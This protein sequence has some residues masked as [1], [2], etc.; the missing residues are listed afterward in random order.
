MPYTP[1][2]NLSVNIVLTNDLSGTIDNPYVVSVD[3]ITKGILHVEHGG[4]GLSDIPYGSIVIGDSENSVTTLTG[5][6]NDLL[7]WSDESGSWV[8]KT[9][10]IISSL[11]MST[12]ENDLFTILDESSGTEKKFNFLINEQQPNKFLASP[13]GSVGEI[14]ARQIHASDLPAYFENITIN[15]S[16]FSGTFIGEAQFSSMTGD[17]SGLSNLTSSQI[18]NFQED[19][20]SLFYLGPHEF[21]Q[22]SI[23][24]AS[25][26][27]VTISDLMYA[28][29]AFDGEFI[30]DGSSLE[31]LI[32]GN[33]VN[34]KEE[35][36]G[37]L[38]G[39]F[40]IEIS[41]EG[42]ISAPNII[43]TYSS[44]YNIEI[45]Q[46]AQ[47][48]YFSLSDSLQLNNITASNIIA[49]SLTVPTLELQNINVNSIIAEEISGT[50]YG[51]F[52]GSYSGGGENITNIPNSSLENS[53]ITINGN[54]V[55]L[56]DEI[57]VSGISEIVSTNSNILVSNSGSSVLLEQSLAP[58]FTSVTA[59][60]IEV[61]TLEADYIYG[62]GSNITNI[63]LE[64]IN[65]ATVQNL[66]C[67][68]TIIENAEIFNIFAD[69]IQANYLSGNGANIT[70]IDVANIPG[71]PYL[72]DRVFTGSLNIT[73]ATNE[74]QET[75]A[76]LK[77]NI[78]L[79]SVTASF[80]GDGS[81]L[82]NI[83]TPIVKKYNGTNLSIGNIV[84][85][86]TFSEVSKATNLTKN[87]PIG[88]VSEVDGNII[89][90]Q[91]AGV[92]QILNNLSNQVIGESL[93]LGADGDAVRYESLQPNCYAIQIGTIVENN[94]ILINIKNLW[95]IK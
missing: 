77:N 51:D 91:L 17:G 89:T 73:V 14:T 11:E 9:F 27:T 10:D 6:G 35:V 80:S 83:Q 37:Y 34:L 88:I 58:V 19:V 42:V 71:L 38:S 78:S 95:K 21:V 7:S 13:T 2:E 62:D 53:F 94:Q 28:T 72:F 18:L 75:I 85:L 39:G 76:T 49:Q 74:Y 61:E 30:G 12:E 31:N 92:C 86:S 8:P 70:N 16:E 65:N 48:L 15:D 54:Q 32:A 87:L 79:T 47:E 3:N 50:F 60:A 25:L 57:N 24:T 81:R 56:G 43:E 59:S 33:I 23:E 45:S 93:Y 20:A 1:S 63:S 67:S 5:S 64:N 4:T 84:T 68:S 69:S 52:L 41:E 29:G 26:G 90:V 66:T 44:D 22:A 46:S 36:L 82:T 55:S 40:G